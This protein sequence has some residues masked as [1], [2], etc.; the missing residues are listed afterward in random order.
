[1]PAGL[2]ERAAAGAVIPD[3]NTGALTEQQLQ[4]TV[5]AA[6]ARLR[7]AGVGPALLG[8]LSTVDFEVGQLPGSTLG[9]TYARVNTVVLD[10][11][12]AGHGWFVD[13][14]P[15]ADEEFARDR[16]GALV[17]LPGGP[18]GERMDLLTVVLHE[19]G[20]IVGRGD[21]GTAGHPNNLM[22]DTLAAGVRRTAA[23]DA[24]FAGAGRS[25]S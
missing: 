21:L 9:Y 5:T 7:Q 23:L 10:A 8:R 2:A 4:E 13:P 20:H 3:P 1:M 15:L 14:T 16:T 12:A 17:A 6:L 19:M 18:V 22:D 25:Q 11:D 24:V